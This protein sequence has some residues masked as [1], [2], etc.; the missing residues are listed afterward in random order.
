MATLV[1]C[2]VRLRAEF[3]T[4]FPLR[5][6]GSDGWIGDAAHQAEHSDHNPDSR[7][8]VHAI[9]VDTD[10]GSGAHMLDFVDHLVARRDKRLTYIIFNRVIWSA[11]RDWTGR[12]YT[13]SD[14]HTGHAH[15]SAGNTP[16]RENDTSS[17][18]LEDL[19]MPTAEDIAKANWDHPVADPYDKDAAG[20]PK[21]KAAGTLLGYGGSREGVAVA[22][23]GKLQPILAA[24]AAD[25][26]EIKAK[27]SETS[28]G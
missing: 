24:L 9:D 11:S 19:I 12:P 22:T 4:L 14:P 13:G 18:H 5:D 15:I 7:G 27:L 21:M 20:K 17:Y 8:L 28:A 25:I 23:V 10:L 3:N 26:A 6:K 2:L 1:P 16:A